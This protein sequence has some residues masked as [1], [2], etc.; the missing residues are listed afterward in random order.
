MDKG[1]N[2]LASKI[3]EL[4]I[5]KNWT[6]QDLSKRSGINRVT[7]AS[8]ETGK[9]KNPSAEIFLKLARVF[10]V[11]QDELYKAAGYIN[12]YKSTSER[13][14][15]LEKILAIARDTLPIEYPQYPLELFAKYGMDIPDDIEPIIYMYR[16]RTGKKT[17]KNVGFVVDREFLKPV[18]MPTDIVILETNTDIKAGDVVV[19]VIGNQVQIGKLIKSSGKYILE[20]DFGRFPIPSNTTPVRAKR[21]H[22]LL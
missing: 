5:S 7:L 12:E 4:R 9:I 16:P 21:V 15:S 20:N 8:I 18:I 11:S 2:L 6:Q 14:L 10:G 1:L 22:K 13:K 19:C 3:K 17:G